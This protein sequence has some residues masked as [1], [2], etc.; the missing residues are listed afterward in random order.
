MVGV[1]ANAGIIGAGARVP[2][3]AIGGGG[4]GERFCPSPSDAGSGGFGGGSGFGGGGGSQYLYH[5]TSGVA[6]QSISRQGLNVSR[7]GVSY[8]TNQRNLLP[9]QTQIELALPANRPLPNAIIRVNV[10][11]FYP[12]LIRRTTGN[13]SG[14]GAGGGTEFLFNRPIPASRIIIIKST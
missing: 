12:L 8:L 3:G 9:L 2:A 6:A 14:Y 5:Y 13:L 1:Q 10:S 7:D 11:G 4:V